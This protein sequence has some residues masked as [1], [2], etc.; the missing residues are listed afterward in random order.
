MYP[1]SALCLAQEAFHRS[2]AANALLANVRVIA[3]KAATA[4]HAE[5]LIAAKR[6]QRQDQTRRIAAHLL[7][8]KRQSRERD[9][10]PLSGNSDCGFAKT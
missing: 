5:S 3:E 4:W 8:E 7:E 6:E 2:R 9:D 1:S 10:R